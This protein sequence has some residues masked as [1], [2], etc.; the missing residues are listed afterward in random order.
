MC[1][2][3]EYSDNQIIFH[4][5]S[6]KYRT[7]IRYLMFKQIT[8]YVFWKYKHLLNLIPAKYDNITHVKVQMFLLNN[9]L[10]Y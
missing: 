6:V 1:V 10:E 5:H 4:L 2:K 3:T 7:M 8:F 9:Y